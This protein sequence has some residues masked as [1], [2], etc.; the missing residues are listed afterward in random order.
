M[1]TTPLWLVLRAVHFDAFAAGT[2][3]T[4]YRRLGGPYGNLER[5]PVGRLVTLARGYSGPR[6]HMQI[7][8]VSVVP[9]ATVPDAA[10]IYGQLARL[11][12]IE[13]S[14]APGATRKSQAV[15]RRG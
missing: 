1:M 14:P 11:V 3:I 13:L 7:K 8:A 9:A 5:L 12:A 15:R 6:L 10:A 2:K 4:E